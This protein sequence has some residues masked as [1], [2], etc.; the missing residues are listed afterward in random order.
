MLPES[1]DPPGFGR[2]SFR[3]MGTTVEVVLP[4]FQL[5]LARAVE[6][7]FC[8]WEA[9]LSRFRPD[10]ELS[11]LNHAAGRRV[12][13]S[14]LLRY[15]IE[16]AL[17]AAE[18][19]G[20]LYD[21]T[22]GSQIE[23]LGYDR[24]FER[25]GVVAPGDGADPGACWESIGLTGSSIYLPRGV[26]IDLGGIAKGMAVDAAIAFL[27]SA[28]AVAALVSAGGDLAVHRSPGDGRGWPVSVE[29]HD[30]PAVIMVE[31]GALATSSTQDRRWH[32]E[33]G[34]T[35]HHLID[36]ATG[37][38]STTDVLR[39]TVAATTCEQADVAAKSA[40]LLGS[41]LGR[42]FLEHHGL[43][44]VLVSEDDTAESSHWPQP[45]AAAR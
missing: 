26:Q 8:G 37:L 1:I 19:T 23:A 24:S 33:N 17:A 7:Q 16:R 27:A 5:V 10:S 35:R 39:A 30:G 31:R 29:L 42:E 34:V 25:V 40:L 18:A 6:N 15:A 21:P 4:H 22:L 28:G 3:A 41:L 11:R 43:A 44:G 38:P 45:E 13:L 14:P 36:P 9:T 2:H 12:E 20:G 32:A